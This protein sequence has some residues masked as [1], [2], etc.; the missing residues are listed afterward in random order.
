[1][2]RGPRGAPSSMQ[3]VG[4]PSSVLEDSP[5]GPAT[6]TQE[7]HRTPSGVTVGGW[8][9]GGQGRQAGAGRKP[10]QASLAAVGLAAPGHSHPRVSPGQ[11]S[12]ARPAGS[13]TWK[14]DGTLHPTP[15]SERPTLTGAPAAPTTPSTRGPG[16][17]RWPHTPPAG[18]PGVQ[19]STGELGDSQVWREHVTTQ[20]GCFWGARRW[21]CLPSE[22]H[23]PASQQE[24]R[25]LTFLP[26][27]SA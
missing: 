8:G 26:F 22:P 19:A 1:M 6:H 24:L 10:R 13:C 15:S 9:V 3:H 4:V 18:S 20:Q 7:H 2:G 23:S 14:G 21:P 16:A 25:E 27:P 11:G 12:P 17:V 5:R